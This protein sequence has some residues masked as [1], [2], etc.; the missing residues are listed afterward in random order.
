MNGINDDTITNEEFNLLVELFNRRSRSDV[1]GIPYEE[2]AALGRAIDLLRSTLPIRAATAAP[3]GAEHELRVALSALLVEYV[4]GRKVGNIDNLPADEKRIL[5]RVRAVLATPPSS[6]VN[7]PA[8]VEHIEWRLN[9]M[10]SQLGDTIAE[11]ERLRDALRKLSN[12]VLGSLPLMEPLARREFG[13]S[14]YNILIQR[15][16]EARALSSG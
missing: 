3:S 6:P 1:I 8:G 16:E 4:A 13:N 10:V 7:R 12:E 2:Y 11:V 14:N 5:D 9:N 15:A